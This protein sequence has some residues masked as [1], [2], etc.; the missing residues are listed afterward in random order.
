MQGD[1]RQGYSATAE[2]AG[3]TAADATTEAAPMGS[4]GRVTAW[5]NNGTSQ[6]VIYDG[7]CLYAHNES[8][9]L[10]HPGRDQ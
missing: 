10:R 2:A 8:T 6:P 5:T 9:Y 4:S 7:A 3:D 1:L